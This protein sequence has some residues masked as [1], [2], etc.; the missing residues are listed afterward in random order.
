V[1]L[2]TLPYKKENWEASKK[3]SRILWRRPRPK[4][5]CGAKERRRRRKVRVGTG[6]A[7]WYS[8][9][10]RA[11][12]SGVRV[13]IVGGNLSLHPRAQTGSGTH[14]ASYT[15][16][17]RGSFP[18]GEVE[19]EADHSPPS[20][21]EIK[22][23]WSYTSTPKYAFKACFSVEK[24]LKGRVNLSLCS[25]KYHAMETYTV[26]NEAPCCGDVWKSER[27][28]PRILNLD[29][30]WRWVVSFTPRSFYS[31][32]RAPGTRYVYFSLYLMIAQNASRFVCQNCER[33]V[34]MWNPGQLCVRKDWVLCP[35]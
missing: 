7:Q 17:T 6:I 2:T 1:G 16:G 19:R 13:P 8:A 31:P 4:L 9:G 25:T 21:V 30:R 28:T 20:S 35:I 18:G 27:I 34:W 3:F 5:G 10:L 11:G 15:M 14:P 33:T 26:L 24:Q 32:E 29:L 12:W 22:N 23:A